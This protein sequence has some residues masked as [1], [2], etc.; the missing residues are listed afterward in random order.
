MPEIASRYSYQNEGDE[1]EIEASI[2]PAVRVQGY[3]SK[4][5]LV[6]VCRWKSQRTKSRVA[7]NSDDYVQAVTRTAFSTPNEKMRIESG[8]GRVSVNHIAG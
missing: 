2:A 5:Q 1:R 8:P 7:K 4:E 6:T 3:F